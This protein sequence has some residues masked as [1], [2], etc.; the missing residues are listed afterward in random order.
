LVALVFDR[1]LFQLFFVD[2]LSDFVSFFVLF[3][4]GQLLWNPY[5]HD[6]RNWCARLY[7]WCCGLGLGFFDS[8]LFVATCCDSRLTFFCSCLVIYDQLDF[9][10]PGL[11]LFGIDIWN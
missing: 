1:H 9:S 7:D 6:S 5:P 10:N 4:F 11:Q 8:F 2:F 3:D